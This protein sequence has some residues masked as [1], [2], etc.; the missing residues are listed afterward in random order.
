MDAVR[1]CDV[2]AES[3]IVQVHAQNLFH[4]QSNVLYVECLVERPCLYR[5]TV[6][7]HYV[8]NYDAYGFIQFG[9]IQFG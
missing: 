1:D 5:A 3:D 8:N 4:S 9:V 7:C 2:E 6:S